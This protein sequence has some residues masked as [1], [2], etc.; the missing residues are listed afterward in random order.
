[1]QV[2]QVSGGEVI[3]TKTELS[4]AERKAEKALMFVLKLLPENLTVVTPSNIKRIE[5]L[6]IGVMDLSSSSLEFLT[7]DPIDTLSLSMKQ[8]EKLKTITPTQE[9]F[10][11]CLYLADRLIGDAADRVRECRRVDMSMLMTRMGDSYVDKLYVLCNNPLE[12]I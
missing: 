10:D 6:A 1:M 4:Q 12:Y 7:Q 11:K 8:R 3:M 9:K 5:D 2:G